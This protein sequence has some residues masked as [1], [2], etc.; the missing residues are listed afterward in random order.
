MNK[1]YPETCGGLVDFLLD[2]ACSN[3]ENEIVNFIISAYRAFNHRP[4]GI[5]E[6]MP[7]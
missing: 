4:G 2:N 7:F 5:L 6:G 3:K 1:E